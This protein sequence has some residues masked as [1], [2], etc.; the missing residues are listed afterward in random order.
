MKCLNINT[1]R[2]LVA[3]SIIR[4]TWAVATAAGLDVS[5]VGIDYGLPIEERGRH[6]LGLV[7]GAISVQLEFKDYLLFDVDGM[8]MMNSKIDCLV[9]RLK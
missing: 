6:V 2:M 8:G 1:R 4:R 7:V 9:S 3:D 5:W